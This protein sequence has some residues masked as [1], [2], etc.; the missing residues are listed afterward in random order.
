[1]IA[2]T[3]PR[4]RYNNYSLR[5]TENGAENPPC[6][7]SGNDCDDT[8]GMCGVQRFL[9]ESCVKRDDVRA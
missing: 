8:W 6:N 2:E 9:P 7:Y 5:R 1:M 3:S 4:H